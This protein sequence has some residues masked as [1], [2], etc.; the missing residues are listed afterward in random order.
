[1]RIVTFASSRWCFSNV[2]NVSGTC[3][4]YCSN[5][6]LCLFVMVVMLYKSTVSTPTLCHKWTENPCRKVKD[7]VETASC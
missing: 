1:M 6:Y 4:L 2:G 5:C 7:H 3:I